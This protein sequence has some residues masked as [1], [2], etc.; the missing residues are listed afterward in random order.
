MLDYNMV[1]GVKSTGIWKGPDER[2]LDVG[3]SG[4][5]VMN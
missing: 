2:Y 4:S 3:V 1:D 5:M